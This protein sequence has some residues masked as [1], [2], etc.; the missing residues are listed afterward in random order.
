MATMQMSD[1]IGW[2]SSTVLLATL[3]HQVRKQWRE[4]SSEGVSSW[5]FVGQSAASLGFFVYSVMLQNWV[6]TVTNGLLV[7][8][9]AVGYF[10]IRQNQRRH[11]QG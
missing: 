11:A 7:G 1:A 3:M 8:N 4:G 10:I 2:A 5:F 6:F 9:S